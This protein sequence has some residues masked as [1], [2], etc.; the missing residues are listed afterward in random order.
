MLTIISIGTIIQ[1]RFHPNSSLLKTSISFIEQLQKAFQNFV[2]IWLTLSQIR[3]YRN[4]I[5]TFFF[6]R[7][8]FNCFY[9]SLLQELLS[10]INFILI[11]CF[12][13]RDS[14]IDQEIAP[15]IHLINKFFTFQLDS[16]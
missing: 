3:S 12:F 10:I 7:W 5:F 15:R 11:W 2:Y 4:K 8:L 6:H 13:R 9:H 16:D 14:L 1:S